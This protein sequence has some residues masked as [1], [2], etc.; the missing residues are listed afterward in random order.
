MFL[1]LLRSLPVSCRCNVF[2]V[3]LRVFSLSIAVAITQSAALSFAIAAPFFLE[4]P[5]QTCTNAPTTVAGAYVKP[6]DDQQEDVSAAEIHHQHPKP[7][8]GSCLLSKHRNCALVRTWEPNITILLVTSPESGTSIRSLLTAR[9][10]YV[11]NSLG[12]IFDHVINGGRFDWDG[13][14]DLSVE[15]QYSIADVRCSGGCPRGAEELCERAVKFSIIMRL[16][17]SVSI[18]TRL[19]TAGPTACLPLPFTNRLSGLEKTQPIFDDSTSKTV[20][21]WSIYGDLPGNARH[22]L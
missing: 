15:H 13:A 19:E 3:N 7:S 10:M 6:L 4:L 2:S 1:H 17:R 11:S 20:E 9:L 21:T 22:H 18:G 12:D 8:V 16:A 14:D 5:S